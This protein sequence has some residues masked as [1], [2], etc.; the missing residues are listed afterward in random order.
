MSRLLE[1]QI[2]LVT[3]ASRGIGRGIALQL[4]Q[5]G[6]AATADDIRQRGGNAVPVY[7][8]HINHTEIAELFDRIHKENGGTLNILVNSAYS[9]R[10]MVKRNKHEAVDKL[11][12]SRFKVFVFFEEGLIRVDGSQDQLDRAFR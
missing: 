3:G 7:R 2:A 1:G 4:G 5:S 9:A 12:G 8:D 6:A 10:M 11:V